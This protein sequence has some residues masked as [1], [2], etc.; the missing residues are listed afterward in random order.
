MTLIDWLLILVVNGGIVLYGLLIFRGRGESFDWYLAAKSIPWWV[1]GLSAFGTAIDS[2]DYVGIVGGSYKLGLAQLSQWWLGI[3]VGWFVLSFFV[4]VPMYRTGVFTNAEWLEFRFGPTARVLAVLI[5][6][7][8]RTNVLGN[9]YFSM[10]LVLS[11]VAGISGVWSW[12]MVLATATTASLYIIRGGLKAGVFTDALQSTAMIVASF[13]LW[14]VVWV[15]TGGWDGLTDKLA[16]IDPKLPDQLLR[17]GG[18]SPDGVSPLVVVLGFI[19]VLTTYAVI[20]QYEAIR[21]LGARSEWDF[22]MAALVASLATAICL[23]FNVSLGPLA[24]AHFPDLEIVDQAY[25]LM[26]KT[27]L[28]PGLVG[29]TVAGLVAAAYSTFDS[30][31]IG[32]STLFVRDIYA[33]FIVRYRED[34]HYTRVGQIAVPFIIALGFI[35]VPFLGSKGMLMFYLRLAGAIAVP[36]MTVILMGVFTRVHRA[37]GLVGLVVGL[38]YGM[39]AILAESYEWGLPVWYTHTW[40]TYLWNIVLPATAM[41]LVSV[42]ITLRRGRATEAELEGLT[43]TRQ[44]LSD[45]RRHL[46]D[47]LK[48]LQGTWLQRTLTDVQ[49]RPEFPFSVGQGGPPWFKRPGIWAVLY[50]CL[51]AFLLFVVL[52]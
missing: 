6:I 41:V 29:L 36:L 52:W 9:I 17:V 43:Y 39:S 31:G 7:Q 8:S 1:I 34:A 50:L 48:V 20:N 13:V 35:Y 5:N 51:A 15:K 32:I 3:A 28:P 47:R 44:S 14:G 18:Y 23:W 26:V 37:T 2:G 27:Y 40:W 12:I 4:I 19:I 16:G 33:R 42:L 24:R 45:Q 10:Y 11:I 46:G 49:A 21:F 38:T 30:I 25:P 22:K